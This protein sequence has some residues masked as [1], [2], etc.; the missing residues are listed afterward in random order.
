MV[1]LKKWDKIEH[2]DVNLNDNLKIVWTRYRTGLTTK[3]IHE[4]I[5]SRTEGNGDFY[6]NGVGW[7]DGEPFDGTS[8]VIYRRKPVVAPPFNFPTGTGAIIE[9]QG[10]GGK[11]HLVH[12]GA[13]KWFSLVNTGTYGQITLEATLSNFRAVT[14]GISL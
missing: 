11:V 9:A 2:E 1:N 10:R 13:G 12:L 8:T 4:G 3:E 5:V 7:E 6:L 14:P